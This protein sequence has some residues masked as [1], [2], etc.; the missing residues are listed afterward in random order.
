MDEGDLKRHIALPLKRE[1]RAALLALRETIVG[2]PES[3]W[4]AGDR[5][6]TQPVRQAAHLLRAAEN[7]LGGRNARVGSRFGVPVESFRSV[8]DVDDCP[9]PEDFLPW[10]DEV[11]QIA[12]DHIDRAVA[13]S[14]TGAPKKYPPLNRPTYVLRH[15]VVHLVTLRQE[16]R[17]RG[18]KI[19]TTD[20]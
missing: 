5:K 8:F 15:T 1:Y 7:Y 12:M 19:K 10:I 16:L 18:I 9:P 20:Y 13:L 4:C 6:G 14:I 3:E 11:E 17:S 2:M